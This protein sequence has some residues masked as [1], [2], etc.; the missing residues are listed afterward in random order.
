MLNAVTIAVSNP[1]PGLRPF[2]EDEEHLFFG[3]ESQVDT[4]V[5]KLARTHFLAVVGTSGSG[6]SSLVNCGL[7][8]ALHRGLMASAGTSWRIA[9]FRPGNNPIRAMARA[10]AR[11]GMLLRGFDSLAGL[12]LDDMVE[13]TLRMSKL[14]VVDIYEQAQLPEATNLLLV[15]DQF[16]ELFR[17]R[18][19]GAS[20]QNREATAFVNLLL[21]P[22]TETRFPIYVVLTMRS[23][24]LGDC[25]EFTG[26]PEAINQSQ[27]LVPRMNREERRAAISGPAGVGGA[28]ISP[29]LLTRLVNDVGD[30]PD[31]LSILQHALNRTWSRWQHEGRAEGPLDLSHYEAIGTMAGALDQHAE[32]AFAELIREREKRNCEKIFKALTDKG[33]DARGIR[34][35]SSLGTLCSL[36]GASQEEVVQVIEV[37]RKPSRS[38][39]MPPQPEL[40]DQQTIIDISHESLMRVWER[41]KAWAHEE[42]QSAQVYRRL[43]ETAALHAAGRAG[44][45]RDP[46]LQ[47]ALEWREREKPT[48]A[49]AGLQGGSFAQAMNFLAQS[50]TQRD[51]ELHDKEE[52]QQRELEQAQALAAEQRRR[53]EEQSRAARRLRWWVGAFG[54]VAL[55]AVGAVI[56]G[57]LQRVRADRQ[58]HS[59]ISKG[60]IQDATNSLELDP[61]LSVL[62]ALGAIRSGGATVPPEAFD[63]LDQATDKA[64]SLHAKLTLVGHESSVVGVT[65]SPDGRQLATAGRD[66]TLK[67]WDAISGKELKS[68]SAEVRGVIF[69]PDGRRLAAAG[70]DR[71]A[72]VLDAS[73]M[74]ELMRLSGHEQGVNAVA[75]SP[76]G[77]RLATASFDTT[78]KVWDVESGR[79]ISTLS[80]HDRGLTAVTFSPD[81]NR[82]ATAADDGAAILWD[83]ASGKQLLRLADNAGGLTAVAFSPDGRRLATASEDGT[84]KLWNAISGKQLF[85]LSSDAGGVTCVAFSPDGGRLATASGYKSQLWD[86]A[87]GRLLRT[88]PGHK[89]GVRSIAFSPDGARLATASDDSTVKIMDV[90]AEL[91]EKPFSQT[92]AMRADR[93][94]MKMSLLEQRKRQRL[95]QIQREA[96]NRSLMAT[97]RS[98]IGLGPA[99]NADWQ[100][101]YRRIPLTRTLTPAECRHYLQA[102]SCPSWV[103]AT[104]II[105]DGQNFARSNSPNAVER[106]IASFRKAKE[107]D[108]TLQLDPELEAKTL[109][110]S[111]LLSQ[112]ENQARSGDLPGAISSFAQANALDPKLRLNPE[113]KAKKLAADG[114]VVR[115]RNLASVGDVRGAVTAFHSA[116]ALNPD[117]KIDPEVETV[118]PLAESLLAKAALLVKQ[119][120][121]TEAVAAYSKAIAAYGRVPKLDPDGSTRA[122]AW[123]DLCWQASVR[124]HAAQVMEACERAV[125]LAGQT[126][127]ASSNIRDS[128]GLARALTGNTAGA[129]EDFQFFI[130]HTDMDDRKQQRQQWIVD[131]R[132]GKNPFSPDVMKQLFVQ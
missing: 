131:L 11:N 59:Y 56:Y 6:K 54:V 42:A 17:Y 84:V 4:M 70:S 88:L 128:R 107:L 80:G 31:Q 7:R 1:F 69:S 85:A 117:L 96:K 72:V 89:A 27:Y 129:I 24:F 90:A 51:Q 100:L 53:A 64:Q 103:E 75:F 132:A 49:W 58:A 36:A 123:N 18:M 34:R 130:D 104:G 110:K 29:V 43:S 99:V 44:L 41:L 86:A 73:S 82:L 116:M 14:G 25:A 118:R 76:D 109:A 97:V 74:K 65:F 126:E 63:M 125:L 93:R 9:Q 105:I 120:R 121:V 106:A 66:R 50:E 26:L 81:R 79:E 111:S 47:L 60:L 127:P 45:W 48:Q 30:N 38:F 78:A 19:V 67:L 62:L 40:L 71:T 55:L 101:E 33:T 46:E 83:A 32:K 5:D 119:D 91:D 2:R 15:V 13:A 102:P 94:V 16:E 87:T 28:E 92:A 108:P 22:K 20:D 3:R 8:P 95:F 57:R 10:L 52:R 77:K 122:D 124:G 113:T 37:F 115:A 21:E 35:P 61:E 98:L 23:D 68:I 39:L 12:S 112:G 114:L